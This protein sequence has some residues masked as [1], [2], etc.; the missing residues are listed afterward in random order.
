MT[1]LP[2]RRPRG[3]SPSI[4]AAAAVTALFA[5]LLWVNFQKGV[6][7]VVQGWGRPYWWLDYSHGLVR[8]GLAGSLFQAVFGRRSEAG[9]EAPVT[10]IHFTACTVLAAAVLAL[11]FGALR[12]RRSLSEQ[13]LVSGVGLWGIAAQFWPTLAFNDGYMDVLVLLT[14]VAAASCVRARLFWPAGL[15]L[16]IGPFIHEYFAFLIPFVLAAHRP[17][18][19]SDQAEFAI[20]PLDQS[21]E[22]VSHR[23][24]LVI[25]ALIGVVA[26]FLSAFAVSPEATRIALARMPIS[27]ADR[28]ILS[29]TSL[30]QS[31]GYALDQNTG[32]MTQ[33]LG[34][35][36]RNA[37]FFCV[38]S[39]IAVLATL[40]WEGRRPRAILWLRAAAALFPAAALLLAWDL[41]RLLVMTNFTATVL[42]LMTVQEAA[43]TRVED[44]RPPRRGGVVPAMLGAALGVAALAYGLAP[45]AYVYY[46][47][48]AA[49][50]FPLRTWPARGVRTFGYE[51]LWPGA[52]V[53]GVPAPPAR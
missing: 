51:R 49:T 39:V 14:A 18:P 27:E 45:M 15:L 16:A 6:W 29:I 13:M 52:V 43:S 37:A 7:S 3:G 25:L 30:S 53:R 2:L 24:A 1:Q 17:E 28:T 33:N 23:R 22:P 34:F 9:L 31:I 26:A 10:A 12:R 35:T 40:M 50:L 36:A 38:P 47:P 44:E 5:A 20:V 42:F 21:D 4:G 32:L 8:R 46:E 11:F 19:A 48:S 41:S